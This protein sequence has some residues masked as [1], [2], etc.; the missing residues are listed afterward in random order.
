MDLRPEAGPWSGIRTALETTVIDRV[1]A[2]PLFGLLDRKALF[3]RRWG[4]GRLSQKQRLEAET[5]LVGLWHGLE[6][7]IRPRAVYLIARRGELDRAFES[8]ILSG[9]SALGLQVVTIGNVSRVC[10]TGTAEERFLLHGLAAEL[11][12]ALARWCHARIEDEAGWVRSRRISPGFPAWPDLSEQRKV[13]RLLRP[14]RI[15]VRLG[16]GFQMIPEY[17]TSAAVL[18]L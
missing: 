5:R 9:R 13:F 10:G 1:P 14:G 16:G 6:P 8:H 3:G 15:G 11:A 17:S 4:L 2:D 7:A 12:E 18:P